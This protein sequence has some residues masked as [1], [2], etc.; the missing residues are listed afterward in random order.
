ML[1]KSKDQEDMKNRGLVHYTPND[2]AK[3]K[4]EKSACI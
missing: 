4:S 3:V 2:A 1:R